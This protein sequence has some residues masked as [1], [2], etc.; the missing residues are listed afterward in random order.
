MYLEKY[1][2]L[3][4]IRLLA[5]LQYRIEALG[6]VLSNLVPLLTMVFIWKHGFKPNMTV[7]GVSQSQMIVY[8]IM[9]LGL[10]D[11]FFF[12]VQDTLF[13]GAREGGV[14]IELSRPYMLLMRYFVEDLTLSL[15]AFLRRFVPL[16]VISSLF[17]HVPFP[18]SFLNALFAAISFGFSFFI[19]WT[20]SA[21]MGLVAFWTVDFG[22]LGMVKDACVRILSG[23]IIPIWFF[24]EPIQIVSKYLPFQYTYQTPL[25]IYIGKT[26][27]QES[28]LP[29]SFQVMWLVV[30]LPL[31]FILWEK[32]KRRLLIHGG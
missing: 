31:L 15:S 6:G 18:G 21:L 5:S 11:V 25:A 29:M 9:A 32:A 14:A 1:L 12:N 16:M 19:L 7:H 4:K 24:P 20:L 27:W 13:L 10:K 23:S 22:N 8:S 2:Y 17:I 26:E 28:F 3:G 30:L